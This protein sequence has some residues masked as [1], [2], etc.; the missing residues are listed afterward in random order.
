MSLDSINKKDGDEETPLDWTYAR[1]YSP[2]RREI[3][4]LLRSKGGKANCYYSTGRYV[5]QG[6]SELNH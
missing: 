1:N 2:I 3:I 6:N 5:G 4:T